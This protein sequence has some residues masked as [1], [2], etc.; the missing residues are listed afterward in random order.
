MVPFQCEFPL[1]NQERL[2]CAGVQFLYP[3]SSQAP[4]HQELLH[5]G[6]ALS[7]D[8][9]LRARL[10]RRLP[11]RPHDRC[12]RRRPRCQPSATALLFQAG[13]PARVALPAGLVGELELEGDNQFF[14]SASLSPAC[15]FTA[16]TASR[17]RFSG[18]R[19]ASEVA[20]ATSPSRNSPPTASTPHSRYVRSI[21]A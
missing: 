14:L 5:P 1:Q 16:R 11:A 19:S 6:D 9:R 12:P 21:S 7:R 2:R 13:C 18:P 15:A 4:P 3:Q 8:E 10:G 20:V 17:H